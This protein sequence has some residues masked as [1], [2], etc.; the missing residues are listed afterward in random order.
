MLRVLLGKGI[1]SPLLREH[2]EQHG[3]V[4]LP[5]PGEHLSQLLHIVAIHRAHIGKAHLLE[6]GALRQQGVLEPAL[7][8]G[9]GPIQI[10]LGGRI[11]LELFLIPFFEVI[12]PLLRAET[13]QVAAEAANI[14]ANGH[15]VI[16]EDDDHRLSR[17]TCVVEALKAQPTG[18]G[19]V[20][21]ES[22]DAVIL[23]EQR[24]G[25]GHT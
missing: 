14:G 1:P 6:H 3:L 21:N 17:R 20:A 11:P 18:H 15:A 22:N 25:V 12:I 19:A 13:G 24:S 8:M 10:L 2:V 9:A 4:L 23:V 7:H 5:G 16:I